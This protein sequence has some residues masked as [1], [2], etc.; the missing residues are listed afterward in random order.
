MC[1]GGWRAWPRWCRLYISGRRHHRSFLYSHPP[2]LPGSA[3][4]SFAASG[5]WGVVPGLETGVGGGGGV[6]SPHAG[7]P[8]QLDWCVGLYY[9]EGGGGVCCRADMDWYESFPPRARWSLSSCRARFFEATAAGVCV[10]L[11]LCVNQ[12]ALSL[13]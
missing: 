1:S 3:P 13:G 6:R 7:P 2:T 9:G 11:I 12:S 8:P 10:A 4:A 5:R